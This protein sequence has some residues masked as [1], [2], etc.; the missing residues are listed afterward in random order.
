LRVSWFGVISGSA[1]MATLYKFLSSDHRSCFEYAA[2]ASTQPPKGTAAFTFIAKPAA[3]G[4]RLSSE[5]PKRRS[6]CRMPSIRACCGALWGHESPGLIGALRETSGRIGCDFG[7]ASP[8]EDRSRR[9]K[10]CMAG[11]AAAR[12][13][14]YRNAECENVVPVTERTKTQRILSRECPPYTVKCLAIRRYITIIQWGPSSPSAGA[15]RAIRRYT[16]RYGANSPRVS[17]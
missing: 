2:D 17:P 7:A 16:L 8:A 11:S 3:V 10:Q 14:W 5:I 1:S 12:A 13:Q 4:M 6:R 15:F 9:T